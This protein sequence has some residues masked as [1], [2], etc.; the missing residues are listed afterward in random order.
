MSLANERIRPRMMELGFVETTH[1]SAPRN[2]RPDSG[3]FSGRLFATRPRNA[4]FLD[5]ATR[6]AWPSEARRMAMG[7]PTGS[8]REIRAFAQHGVAP[9]EI[10]VVFRHWNDE[11][12]WRLE[13][14]RAWGCR[15]TPTCAQADRGSSRGIGVA[16]G[17]HASR[18][19]TGRP[20]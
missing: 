6:K 17:D 13:T 1:R 7:Q 20:S 10:L 19:K 16:T 5:R 9:E 12:D 3:A 2:G 18:W 4:G 8:P 11:A 14:L 15:H